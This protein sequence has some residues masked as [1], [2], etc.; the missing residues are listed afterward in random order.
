MAESGWSS[1]DMRHAINLGGYYLEAGLRDFGEWS[2]QMVEDAGE[3]IRPYLRLVWTEASR[4]VE[5]AYSAQGASASGAA[6]DRV[7]FCVICGRPCGEGMEVCPDCGN[8][9]NLSAGEGELPNGG[10]ATATETTETGPSREAWELVLREARRHKKPWLAFVLALCLGPLGVFYI[11][12]NFGLSAVVVWGILAAPAAMWAP[13]W[14][15]MVWVANLLLA[16]HAADLAQKRNALLSA[17]LLIMAEA[18]TSEELAGVFNFWSGP[19]AITTLANEFLPSAAFW[20]TL[21]EMVRQGIGLF[22]EHA[23]GAGVFVL[24]LSPIVALVA[25]WF[26]GLI[27]GIVAL[28]GTGIH[29]LAAKLSRQPLWFPDA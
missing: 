24:V 3:E 2:E 1:E 14:H 25:T 10:E 20:M 22:R 27:G 18:P 8:R 21:V 17:S 23:V 7:A 6:Q 5:E 9:T 11:G 12:A 16:I 4:Q 28:L 26:Y 29:W 19:Y 15:W 13:S